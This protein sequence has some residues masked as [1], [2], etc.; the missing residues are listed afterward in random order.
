MFFGQAVNPIIRADGSPNFAM[1]CMLAG[2]VT[3]I[4]GDPIAIFV[5]RG[6]V[7][8]AAIATVLGQLVTAG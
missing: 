3:N 1:G 6:G 5:F 8:G 2:A 7:V 4:I